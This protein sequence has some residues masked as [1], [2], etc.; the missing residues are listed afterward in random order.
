M[1]RPQRTALADALAM[2]TRRDYS[3]AGLAA[4]LAGKGHSLT[5][6]EAA[7]RQCAEHGYLDDRRF[8]H[9]RLQAR[10]RRRP[11]GRIDALRDLRRQGLTET[12]AEAVAE[13]VFGEHGG[14]AA[15]LDDA[16]ERWVARHGEPEDLAAAKRCFD[17]LVRRSF[18]RYLVLQKLSPWLD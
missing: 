10:L 17:H 4:K 1:N 7:L 5:D 11:A 8:G 12:M 2:L 13:E 3:R 16:F 6:V 9:D 18:P 14:E 15:V